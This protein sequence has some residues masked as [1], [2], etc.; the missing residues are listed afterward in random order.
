MIATP[1]N[2]TAS[3]GLSLL[4]LLVLGTNWG[5][6]F[7]LGKVGVLGGL[8]PLSYAFWQ[9]LGGG[10]VLLAICAWRNLLPPVRLKHLRYYL[11]C[12]ATNVAMPNFVALTAAQHIPVGIIVLIIS[13][14]PLLTYAVSLGFGLERFSPRKVGGLVLGLTG[15]LMILVPKSSLPSPDAAPW[16]A[17]ALIT[18][19]CYGLSNV[20][21][22][23][24]RPPDVASLSLG[25]AMQIAAGLVLLAMALLVGTVHVPFPP[26]TNAEIANVAHIAI[27]GFGA[28]VFFELMRMR[29]PVVASQVGYIVCLSGVFW[30][31]LFFAEQHSF[32]IWAAMATIFTGLALVT[33]PARKVA[34]AA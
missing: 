33:W 14:A 21:L 18:P 15:A 29:G 10:L 13:L 30:G 27:S 24:A 1:T 2:T 31:K 16:V 19:L 9:C 11:I 8:H 6:G 3:H 28:L 34:A 17:F 7:T 26:Q 25:S 20:Y 32:W 4:M 23:W 12:G 22:G 5:L